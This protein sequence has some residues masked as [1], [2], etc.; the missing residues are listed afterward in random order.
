MIDPFA[1]DLNSVTIAGLA[2]PGRARV[3]GASKP[4]NWDIKPSYGYSGATVVFKGR[5]LAEF[6]LYLDFWKKS[7]FAEWEVFKKVFDLPQK[8][9]GTKLSLGIH[10]PLLADL[11]I[12][13]VVLKKLGQFE[14]GSNGL[15]TVAI[16]LLEY[17][18]PLKSI[19]KPRGGVPAVDAAP[20]AAKTEA[21]RAAIEAQK[22]LEKAMAEAQ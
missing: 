14:R 11:G 12:E 9:L 18:A 1:F 6:T 13:L 7:Q 21:Q 4:L 15:W 10:H 2:S 20:S 3:Q 5:G 8:P 19:V 22:E 16:E 17:R